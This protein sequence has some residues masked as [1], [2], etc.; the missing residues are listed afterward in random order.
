MAE[1]LRIERERFYSAHHVLMRLAKDNLLIAERKEPGWSDDLF[2][3]LVFSSLVLE[4]FSNAVGEKVITSWGDFDSARPQAKIRLICEHLDIT[5]DPQI[6]PWAT[7]VWLAKVRN[8][9]AHPKAVLL[10]DSAVISK[11]DY[12][13]TERSQPLSKLEKEITIDNAKKSVKALDDVIDMIC[14]RLT[15]EENFGISGDMWSSSA[16]A[17]YD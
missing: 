16:K 15:P 8:L 12:Y 4:A 3:S 10:S 6:E 1:K 13:T 9:V 7:L 17:D 2:S 14:H 11:D 5:Y